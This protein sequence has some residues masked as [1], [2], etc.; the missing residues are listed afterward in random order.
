MNAAE[1]QFVLTPY[2]DHRL[3]V[4]LD[5]PITEYDYTGELPQDLPIVREILDT[6]ANQE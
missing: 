6:Y 2:I 5:V 1:R 4:F 3:T